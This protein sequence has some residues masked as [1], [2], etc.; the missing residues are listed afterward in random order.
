MAEIH[1]HDS[2]GKLHVEA[3]TAG[4][5]FTL[6]K[7]FDI[8]GEKLNREGYQMRATVDNQEIKDPANLI[9]KDGQQFRLDYTLDRTTKSS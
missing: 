9:L 5:E 2:T 4:K 8:W 7:F 6:Q 3:V 1:T